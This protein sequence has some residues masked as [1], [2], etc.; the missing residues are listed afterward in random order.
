MSRRHQRI[1]CA[2]TPLRE[3]YC[4]DYE[5]KVPAARTEAERSESGGG[6]CPASQVREQGAG[7]SGSLQSPPLSP[8]RALAGRQGSE[9]EVVLLS[10]VRAHTR[11]LG[12][13]AD[14]RRMCVALSRARHALF[15]FGDRSAPGDPGAV[16][17][18][19]LSELSIGSPPGFLSKFR[20]ICDHQ[21]SSGRTHPRRSR[22][23][24]AAPRTLSS[25]T[26]D[27]QG[28]LPSGSSGI[29]SGR[30]P[31]SRGKHRQKDRTLGE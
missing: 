20:C 9:R 28:P 13:L 22:A 8:A 23:T 27:A 26:N 31:P 14:E 2:T 7:P 24:A 1:L 30:F 16:R 12:F 11:S 25:V 19:A 21:K 29:R 15:I 5:R 18:E 6:H 4:S 3:G 17:P 10:T